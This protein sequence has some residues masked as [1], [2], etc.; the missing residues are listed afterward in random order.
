MRV[1]QATEMSSFDR[2]HVWEQREVWT[3]F[4]HLAFEVTCRHSIFEPP[5]SLKMCETN[6]E[7]GDPDEG[8]LQQLEGSR[9][10]RRPQW[11]RPHKR[12]SRPNGIMQ[13]LRDLV[14]AAVEH[15]LRSSPDIVTKL[16][17]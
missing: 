17:M 16:L 6:L 11:P 12:R 9:L 8:V 10:F 2:W 13:L 5:P 3:S 1:L 15:I 4:H 7:N 14:P